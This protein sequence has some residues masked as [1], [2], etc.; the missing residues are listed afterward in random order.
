MQILFKN[1]RLV[2]NRGKPQRSDCSDCCMP[3]LGWYVA[4][5]CPPPPP[6]APDPC[7]NSPAVI[8]IPRPFLCN[9]CC[10]RAN[11]IVTYR[12]CCYKMQPNL[13]ETC[14]CNGTMVQEALITLTPPPP[15]EVVDPNEVICK[16]ITALCSDQE[17]VPVG[18]RNCCLTT[19]APSCVCQCGRE[20]FGP[21][22]W[23][24]KIVV[25]WQFQGH[26]TSTCVSVE[27]DRCGPYCTTISE[28]SSNYQGYAL[29][30]YECRG[31]G[32]NSAAWRTYS[33]GVC[34]YSHT[35]NNSDC[36]CG[37]LYP[38]EVGTVGVITPTLLELY[39]N[40]L[41]AFQTNFDA[42]YVGRCC[43]SCGYLFGPGS[44]HQESGCCGT[45]CDEEIHD[46][47]ASYRKSQR[48]GCNGG[49]E[50]EQWQVLDTVCGS[51]RCQWETSVTCSIS[52]LERCRN[53]SGGLLAGDNQP[54][55]ADIAAEDLLRF[56]A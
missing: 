13:G 30:I 27:P 53:L 20:Y 22:N 10:A 55:T 46:D 8:Y 3:S 37:G 5:R 56:E 2:L 42:I 51:V 12:N 14:L 41:H 15:E 31:N 29:A 4:V 50:T 34:N 18:T 17:C 44:S 24:Q 47:Y 26:G 6:P 25:V 54:P 48:W 38:D 39:R 32:I 11:Q 45:Y 7:I 16:P 35:N 40:Q 1:G 52:T 43:G 49:Y 19:G 23:G 9:G 21:C 33:E 36:A 28:A